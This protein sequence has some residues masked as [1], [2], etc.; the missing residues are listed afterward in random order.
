MIATY[1]DSCAANKTTGCP[2]GNVHNVHKQAVG[3]RMA[4]QLQAMRH[5]QLLGASSSSAAPVIVS[6][7]VVL[8]R[9]FKD[10]FDMSTVSEI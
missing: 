7:S 2:H 3:I 8:L 10:V 6:A 9:H 1:D 4:A 5:T